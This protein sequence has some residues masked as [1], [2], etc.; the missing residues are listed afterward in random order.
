MT[1][2]VNSRLNQWPEDCHDQTNDSRTE[3]N[4]ERYE[5]FT[6]KEGQDIWQF[7]VVIVFV[8]GSRT[9]ETSDNTNEYPHVKGWLVEDI[10]KVVRNP[11]G[12]TE[13]IVNH[14]LAGRIVN[15]C[16]L[17]PV[18]VTS[19]Q[20]NQDEGNTCGESTTS[21]FLSPATTDSQGKEQVKVVQKAPTKLGNQVSD[22]HPSC[23]C[24]GNQGK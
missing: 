7:T 23:V 15:I 22:L 4:H 18:E 3:D 17:N 10:D 11:H 5:T 12:S 14:S 21:F 16:Y 19:N 2:A 6:I 1:K 13:N 8:V 24:R 9:N 20:V